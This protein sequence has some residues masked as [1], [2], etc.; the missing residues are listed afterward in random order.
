MLKKALNS[1]VQK[2]YGARRDNYLIFIKSAARVFAGLFARN[3]KFGLSTIGFFDCL[4]FRV[5]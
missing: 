4:P 5:F 3:L 1:K 2:L